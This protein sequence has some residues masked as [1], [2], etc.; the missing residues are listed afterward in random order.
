MPKFGSHII[1][2]EELLRRRPD[3]FQPDL[4]MNSYR[5]G[6]IGPDTTLFI[7]DPATNKPI[8][9][10]TFDMVLKVMQDIQDLEDRVNAFVEQFDRPFENI[11][12]WLTGDLYPELKETLQIT[13]SA[14]ALLLKFGIVTVTG[15][16]QLKNP[17]Y[18]FLKDLPDNIKNVDLENIGKITDPTWIVSAFANFGFPFRLFGHPFTVDPPYRNSPEKPGDYSNWWWMDMLHYRYPA[19]FARQLLANASTPAQRSYALGYLTHVAGDTAGHPF[20]NALV[21]GPFRNHAQRHMVLE[22]LADIWLWDNQGR[23]DIKGSQLDL[24]IRVNDHDE[25]AIASLIVETMKEVYKPP[26]VPGLL[27]NGYPTVGE[28]RYAYKSMSA[29]LKLST[30]PS[31]QRPEPPP[32]DPI[33]ALR[34]VFRKLGK[35][36]PGPFP[37]LS[38]KPE[39]IIKALWNWFSK[40]LTYLAML[41]TLPVATVAAIV[42]W[43]PRWLLY[44]YR[45]AVYYLISALR[46]LICL[47]G[48]GYCSNDEFRNFGFLKDLVRTPGEQFGNYPVASS[49]CKSP[50]YW[51]VRPD[52]LPR[53]SVEADPTTPHHPTRRGITPDWMLDPRNVPNPDLIYRLG[54]TPIA[55]ECRQFGNNHE[56]MGIFGNAPDYAALL[57]D[58]E[59]LWFDFDLD[60]DRGNGYRPWEKMPPNEEFL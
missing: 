24:M 50:Y 54:R 37:S 57:L 35:M 51:L 56:L 32:D 59:N 13:L 52:D 1:F 4:V 21:R 23:G 31:V 7:F 8:V 41:A 5:L 18:D 20:I 15:T 53:S 12:G 36:D 55:E 47:S 28:W 44:L 22:T 16:I 42:A 46:M 27:G 3:L 29:Y 45:M 49:V 14:A 39:D 30:T 38:G 33:D 11:G 10:E 48:W 26:M 19:T 43:A 34:D 17:L 60:G 25:D 2:A 58:E 9:R 40:G 6:S